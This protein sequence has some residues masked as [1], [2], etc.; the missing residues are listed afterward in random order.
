MLAYERIRL[1]PLERADA[2]LIVKWRNDPEVLRGLHRPIQLTKEQHLEWFDRLQETTERLEFVIE[3]IVGDV[4]IGTVGLSH[5]DR[6]NRR[7]E[8]GILIGERRFRKQG[9]AKEASIALLHYAFCE[10]NLW[11]VYLRVL[12]HLQEAIG[13]YTRMGFSREGL[14]RDEVF[15]EGQFQDVL[16]MSILR[17]EWEL[18]WNS[19][20]Q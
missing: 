15:R 19:D 6:D 3:T 18:T 7:A 8:Y 5:M 9:Y 10:L 11:R 20:K 17:P 16:I 13:F 1:R 2:D 12:S 14:L 4:P